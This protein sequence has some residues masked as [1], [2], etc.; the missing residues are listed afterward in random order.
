MEYTCSTVSKCIARF[1][2]PLLHFAPRFLLGGY[3]AMNIH[4]LFSISIYRNKLHGTVTCPLEE[5]KLRATGCNTLGM[6]CDNNKDD[7]EASL[8]V[9][10]LI[11]R[12]RQTCPVGPQNSISKHY[13]E[14]K[15]EFVGI[16]GLCLWNHYTVMPGSCDS[17][18]DHSVCMNTYCVQWTL[19]AIYFKH[20]LNIVK[21][22]R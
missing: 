17:R 2:T 18:G 13:K 22:L 21:C 5:I 8:G 20:E 1:N 11:S 14:D 10:L 3:S 16:V 9:C 19:D 12:K 15:W 4:C 7:E 6:L